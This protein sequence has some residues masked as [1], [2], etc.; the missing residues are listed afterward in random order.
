M[1]RRF[2]RSALLRD[3]QQHEE[4][5]RKA[6]AFDPSNGYSQVEG[7]GEEANRNYGE[8]NMLRTIIEQIASGEVG[9]EPL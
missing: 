8:W 6:N 3:L 2:S 5:L 1:S 4:M 9:G 7:R